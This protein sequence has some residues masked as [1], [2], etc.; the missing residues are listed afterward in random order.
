MQKLA[1]PVMAAVL[2]LMVVAVAYLTFRD[3]AREKE[4]QR[5]L[6]LRPIDEVKPKPVTKASLD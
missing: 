1:L 3:H 5:K 2:L 6:A 4:A